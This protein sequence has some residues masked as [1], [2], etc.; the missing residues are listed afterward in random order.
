ML[1]LN[2]TRFHGSCS[3]QGA[4]FEQGISC[5]FARF[6]PPVSFWGA[7][8]KRGAGFIGVEFRNGADFIEVVFE[9]MAD[10]DASQFTDNFGQG[11]FQYPA[12]FITA[13]FMY[14]TSFRGV[15]FGSDDGAD[16]HHPRPK[17]RV[18]FTGAEFRAKTNF[19]EAVFNGVP[20]F[21]QTTLHEDTDFGR[22]DWERAESDTIPVNDAIRA[23]ERLELIMSKLE[24]PLDQHRFFRLK[25]RARRR[26]DGRFLRAVNWLFET[27]ADYGWGVERAF[28]WWL[29]HWL[30]ASLLLFANACFGAITVAWWKLSLVALGTGVCQRPCLSLPDG[31]QWISGGQPKVAGRQ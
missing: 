26:V 22:I 16:A 27:I 4:I 6:N 30:V 31:E 20:A 10:F 12:N 2:N 19:S 8:F 1:S 25:M 29:G 23:W 17:P 9:E 7:R 21:F 24:K 13:T 5:A 14:E 3:F 28:S 11:T 15:V 18:N